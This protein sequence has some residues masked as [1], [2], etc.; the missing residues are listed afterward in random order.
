MKTMDKIIISAITAA[1]TVTASSVIAAEKGSATEQGEKCYGI[2]KA[3]LNDCATATQSCAG[4]ATKNNQPDAF[5]FLPKGACE[6]IV[7]GSLT[8]KKEKK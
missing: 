6:K 3:G 8:S 1:F 5:I 7:G 4:S 2:V